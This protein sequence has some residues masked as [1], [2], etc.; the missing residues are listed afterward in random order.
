MRNAFNSAK[1]NFSYKNIKVQS[2]AERVLPNAFKLKNIKKI[3]KNVFKMF[4]L[5]DSLD[6]SKELEFQKQR[7]EV[8]EGV[9]VLLLEKQDEGS[10]TLLKKK[11]SIFIH[12]FFFLFFYF[13]IFIFLY[14]HFYFYIF[15]FIFLFSFLFLYFHFYFYIFIFIRKLSFRYLCCSFIFHHKNFQLYFCKIFVQLKKKFFFNLL[16]NY[17]IFFKKRIG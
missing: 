16:K 2:F 14:F 8:E 10:S 15:I 3:P 4:F 9:R 6:V 5:V 7:L 17:L 13:H 12:I 1:K 11:I